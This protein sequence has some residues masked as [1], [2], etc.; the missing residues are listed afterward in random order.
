MSEWE[1]GCHPLA[2]WR[3]EAIPYLV[4]HMG[5]TKEQANKICRDTM[6]AYQDIIDD[7]FAYEY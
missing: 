3:Y 4:K 7:F 6:D 5:M 2:E 1:V